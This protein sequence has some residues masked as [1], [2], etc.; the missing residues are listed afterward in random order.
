MVDAFVVPLALLVEQIHLLAGHV[1]VDHVQVQRVVL[2]AEAFPR[3]RVVVILRDG[4][5]VLNWNVDLLNAAQLQRVEL[6]VLGLREDLEAEHEPFG[7]ESLQASGA[8]V[9]YA[10]DVEGHEREELG[11]ARVARDHAVPFVLIA[12]L[13]V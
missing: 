4:Y 5:E 2:L 10:F 11:L 7:R 9:T 12:R 8:A 1:R 3:G 13:Q 6:Q